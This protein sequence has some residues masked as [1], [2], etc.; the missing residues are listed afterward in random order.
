LFHPYHPSN[1]DDEHL[2]E[3]LLDNNYVVDIDFKD[4]DGNTMLSNACIEKD[5][6]AIMFLVEHGAS[7]NSKN[8]L[9]LTPLMNLVL[10]E[11]TS[12]NTIEYLLD[13]G[14]KVNEQDNEGNTALHYALLHHCPFSIVQYLIRKGADTELKNKYGMTPLQYS[15]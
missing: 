3:F 10:S 1:K 4:S 7:V 2:A 6:D 12:S 11:P 9:G 13:H 8:K 5:T 14:A 15:E